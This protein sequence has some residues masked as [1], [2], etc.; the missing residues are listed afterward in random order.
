MTS[1]QIRVLLIEDDPDDILLV[2]ESL[3][4]VSLGKVKLEYTGRLSRGLIEL[5]SHPYDVVLLDLNLPD[6]RGLET[7]KTVIK[8]YPKVPVVVLSGLADDVTTIEAVRRGAQDYLVKGEISGP[9]LVRVLRYAIERKQAEAVLRESEARYRALVETTPNGITLTD[10]DGKLVLCNQ[11]TAALHGY[12]N[13][14]EM[15]G[16][17]VYDLVVPA[18]R[19]LASLNTQKTLN[20]GR[21]MNVE[22]SL[23]RKDGSHFPAEISA[24]LLRDAVGAPAGFIGTT[25]DTTERIRALEAEKRLI[26]LREEFIASVSNDLRNPLFSLMGYLDLLRSGKVNDSSLHN[27]Y[28]LRATKDANRLLGMVNELL[29]FSLSESQILVLDY[30]KV[31]LVALIQ[32]VLQSFRE[33]ADARRISLKYAPK[34]PALIVDVDLSRMRRVLIN[35]VENAIKFSEMDDK[36]LV[37]IESLNGTAIISVIDQ[38]CGI[39]KEDYSKIFEK[40]YQVN[41]NPNKNTFGMGLGLYISTLIIE[42]HG[43]SITV[44]SKLNTGSKF[45]VTIPVNKS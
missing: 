20:E 18:D 43:G 40:Y 42:A 6:S 45:T 21:V 44:E 14:E 41:H 23:V 37:K 19:Q 11:Q 31:D 12:D 16:I 26:K 35:L 2:K 36:V 38:G 10:L 5:S 24:V 22:Y 33:Q 29:D 25:R 34:D 3:A 28:L 9:M 32:D 1:D 4:E 27:E 17:N 8:S 15:I 7:L 30:A 13:P 39:P